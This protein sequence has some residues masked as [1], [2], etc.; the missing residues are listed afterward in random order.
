MGNRKKIF[1]WLTGVLLF[2]LVTFP[3]I[4]PYLAPKVINSN[5]IKTKLEAT[6]S[7]QV[8]KK[9]QFQRIGL[10]IFPLPHVVIHQGTMSIPDTARGS[11]KS[12][13]VYPELFPL[14][15]AEL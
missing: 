12:L 4:F 6:I 9:V 13:A 2:I 10:T 14:L 7:E 5:A 3:L 8:G 1:L 15:K 11:L